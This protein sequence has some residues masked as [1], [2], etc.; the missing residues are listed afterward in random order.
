MPL[1]GREDVL[2]EDWF[3]TTTERSKRVRDLY[4]MVDKAMPS[5][6]TDEWLA[7]L[8]EADIP[9]GR[10]NSLDTIFE[11]PHLAATGFW[12][13]HEHPTEGP[14]KIPRH[15]L[16]WDVDEMPERHAPSLGENTVEVLSEAGMSEP[17]IDALLASGAARQ[18]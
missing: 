5:R 6:T 8:R 16:A 15:P 14:L 18:A 4:E 11:D 1:I 17:E 10:V 12:Q 2:A 3:Q 7:L 13:Q 9:C